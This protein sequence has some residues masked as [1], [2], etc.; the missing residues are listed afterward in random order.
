MDEM[1]E[2]D[3]LKMPPKSPS[4]MKNI[5]E[6]TVAVYIILTLLIQMKSAMGLESMLEYMSD[7]RATM[8]KHNPKIK[9]AVKK[10]MALLVIERFLRN[11][12]NNKK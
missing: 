1:F 2:Y 12:G 8:E 7:Y 9:L 4:K 5:S 10:A 6:S 3:S 11:A